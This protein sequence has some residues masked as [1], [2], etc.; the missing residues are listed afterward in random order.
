L[1]PSM[2]DH[3]S[4]TSAIRRAIVRSVNVRG[5]A[6]PRSSSAHVHGAET[7]A[8]G[9]ARTAYVAAIVAL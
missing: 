6:A 3:R 9:R 2:S 4:P 1:R 7:G 5:V 8:P